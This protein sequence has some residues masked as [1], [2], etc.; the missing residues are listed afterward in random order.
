MKYNRVEHLTQNFSLSEFQSRDGT[1]VGSYVRAA[2]GSPNINLGGVSTQNPRLEGRVRE[3]V[4]STSLSDANI[5]KIEGYL[6]WKWDGIEASN[7]LVAKLP[8]SHPY[9]NNPPVVQL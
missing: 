5:E 2:A 8:P 1:V 3:V 4:C 6:A 9:K 7:N